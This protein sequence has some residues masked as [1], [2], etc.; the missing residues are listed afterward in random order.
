MYTFQRQDFSI[1]IP[2]AH[3]FLS[4]VR[5]L[6]LPLLHLVIAEQPL[7]CPAVIG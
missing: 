1:K 3:R 5:F 6:L 4:P 7:N 2:E